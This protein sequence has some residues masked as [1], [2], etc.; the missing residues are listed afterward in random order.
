MSI[1]KTRDPK[2][3]KIAVVVMGDVDRS[4]RMINHAL[5][6]A[7]LTK[8]Y[9][10]DLIGYQGN[11]LPE[12]VATNPRIR[13]R[14]LSTK[15]LK[16]MQKLPKVLYLVYAVLRIILQI[17]QLTYIFLSEHYD[18]VLMQN[19]PCVPLLFVL[20]LLK[21]L[22]LS[23]TQIIIDWHNYGYSILRV[24]RVNKVLVFLAKLYEV[25]LARWAEHHLCVSKAMQVDLVN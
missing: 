20:V 4:P 24:N 1:C 10:A 14:Y 17:I 5:S 2:K 18:Y 7:N 11:S 6:V 22:R 25:K 13:T 19:P 9:Y 21:A 3:P 16:L 8:S 15:L 23:R 12:A